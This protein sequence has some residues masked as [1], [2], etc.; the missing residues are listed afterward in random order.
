MADLITMALLYSSSAFTAEVSLVRLTNKAG[1]SPALSVR[2]ETDL[3]LLTTG[4]RR[5]GRGRKR[6]KEDE[7]EE[8]A[9]EV[10]VE[11]ERWKYVGWKNRMREAIMSIFEQLL[12]AKASI[13][14]SGRSCLS[15]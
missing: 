8:D 5:H 3:V 1:S 15:Y 11:E 4:E 6:R 7:D 2:G 10:E 13:H 9:D 14:Q 12:T